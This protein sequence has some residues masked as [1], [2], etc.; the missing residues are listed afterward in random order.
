MKY[1][2]VFLITFLIV[3]PLKAQILTQYEKEKII[4]ALE[5]SSLN[6]RSAA[7]EAIIK[8]KILEAEDSLKN[9]IWRDARSIQIDYLLALLTLNSTITEEFTLAFLDT[10]DAI[11]LGKPD[12]IPYALELKV[13]ATEILFELENYSTVEYVFELIDQDKP[14][15][16]IWAIDLL[17]QIVKHVPSYTELAKTE[18][19]YASTYASSEVD[20]LNSLVNLIFL[21]GEETL[22]ILLIACQQDEN[23][24]IR[25]SI[26]AQ[27]L[28]DEPI[29]NIT[30]RIQLYQEEESTIRSQIIDYLLYRF[31]SASDFKFVSDY[32]EQE[33]DSL[34]KRLA[35]NSLTA[36][37]PPLPDSLTST[38]SM[39]NNLF[40]L[41]DTLYIYTWL[42][43]LQ[44]K[45]ELQSIIQSA[46]SNLQ[47]GDSVACAVKFKE[48]QDIVDYVYKDSLNADPRFVTIE[49]WKFLYWNAQY[50]LDRLPAIPIVV[51]AD[52]DV[53]HPAMS[54]VNPGA[55]TMEVKGSGF[56]SSLVVYFN[57]NSRAT[58][59]VSDSVLNT[60]ILSTDVSAAGNFPVW[61]SDGTT[62]S[63]TL[64]YKVVSALPQP[65]RPVL[66][67][68]TNNGDG[69][70]TASSATRMR[71]A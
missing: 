44:F 31:G 4:L 28:P 6:R 22:P 10:L 48:F 40:D 30:L 42:A 71:T 56:S 20:R 24:G 70:Y 7:L 39:I 50:I 25:S 49:G 41:S 54:L 46:K 68:V 62:N 32:V 35:I 34:T 16:N 19:I 55:F 59:F 61:V 1:S 47:V 60:Q 51:A 29:V 57:G 2:I 67:C 45:N 58:T 52:I 65:V 66:E 3:N 53:I 11:S 12:F 36:F 5:D 17:P 21:F 69:T 18:L 26:I 37:T 15:V 38:E 23:P 13:R 8:Y 14:A 9:K 33:I 27:F 63:D 64:I 43:D